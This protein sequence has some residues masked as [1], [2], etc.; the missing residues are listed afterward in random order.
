MA[1]VGLGKAVAWGAG[2]AALFVALLY[3]AGPRRCDRDAPATI[4]QRIAASAAATALSVAAT[5]AAFPPTRPLLRPS[6]AG[7][8]AAALLVVVLY[9]GPLVALLLPSRFPG[10]MT[11]KD[12][13]H[14]GFRTP[15]TAVRLLVAAPLSEELVF[16][17]AIGGVFALTAARPAAVCLGPPLFFA[18]AH[19]HHVYEAVA[20][21][22][23]PLARA[24]AA[25]AFQVAYTAVFGAFASFLML[26]TGSVLPCI[27]AHAVCNFFGFPDVSQLSEHS[28]KHCFHTHTHTLSGTPFYLL[29]LP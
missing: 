10:A 17:F 11:W 8:L 6:A 7:A 20:V 12:L 14:A 16:R 1:A 3:A 18:V 4:R 26:R 21:H 28:H 15:L 13:V 24:L 5:A 22:K 27:V 19:V 29:T 9:V 2:H 23:V 25:A